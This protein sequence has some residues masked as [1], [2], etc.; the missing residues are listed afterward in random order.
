MPFQSEFEY[1]KSSRH[2]RSAAIFALLVMT[3]VAAPAGIIWSGDF[4][5]GDFRQY[6]EPSDPNRVTFWHFTAAYGRPIQYGYQPEPNH[7]G[8]GD[9]LSLVSVDGRT[10]NGIHYPQ[11][12][13]RGS[14]PYAAKLTVK[15]S[16]N[17][18]EPDDCDATNCD[19]RRGQLKMQATHA[20]YYNALP[21][22]GER[23]VSFSYYIPSDWSPNGSGFGINVFGI[24]M[25]KDSYSSNGYFRVQITNNAW[26]VIHQWNPAT[27]AKEAGEPWQYRMFYAGDYDGQPYPRSDM[28]PDGLADFP[29]V[30]TSIDALKSVNKGGWTDWI[31][32]F[33]QDHRG[34]DQ[35]GTGWLTLWK[36]EDSGPWVK[37][38]HIVPKETTRGGMT[39]NHG[40]GYNLS[41]FSGSDAGAGS[42]VGMYMDKAQVWNSPN[43]RVLY[44]ANHKIGDPNAKFSD[45]SPDGT[46][47]EFEAVQPNTPPKPPEVGPVE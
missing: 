29:D 13:T 19:R 7:V 33:K 39:F 30:Q 27:N 41:A 18:T 16:A 14:S 3:P 46:S 23:W 31:L 45:M 6:H 42:V 22:M 4:S 17:G 32:H 40:I 25:R 20:D 37:V 10:V 35:G 1:S 36:R 12:P 8:N 38:L 2:L 24:K 26:Q 9:L 11:G 15:N 28:W 47:P 21:H 44:V 5:T 34:S 43:N